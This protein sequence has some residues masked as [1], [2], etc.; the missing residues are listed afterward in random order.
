MKIAIVNGIKAH[1]IL[2]KNDKGSLMRATALSKDIFSKN[3]GPGSISVDVGVI[4]LF[5]RNSIDP[6]IHT[7]TKTTYNIWTSRIVV[8]G[9]RNIAVSLWEFLF[10][11]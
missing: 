1:K 3:G 6:V 11:E 2:G 9:P 10:L 4:I 5:D 8:I 7:E